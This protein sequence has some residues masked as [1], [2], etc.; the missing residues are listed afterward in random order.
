M[1]A[2]GDKVTVRIVPGQGH[3]ELIAPETPAWAAA[4]KIIANSAR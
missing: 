4:V 1:R 3:V 2:R